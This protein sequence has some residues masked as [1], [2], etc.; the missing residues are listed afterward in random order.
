MAAV[1]GRRR[2]GPHHPPSFS[3]SCTST[4]DVTS[5]KTTPRTNCINLPS[6]FANQRAKR[7]KGKQ[8]NCSRVAYRRRR[9]PSMIPNHLFPPPSIPSSLSFVACP[10]PARNQKPNPPPPR[11]HTHTHTHDRVVVVCASPRADTTGDWKSASPASAH[12]PEVDWALSPPSRSL[13][14]PPNV[15]GWWGSRHRAVIVTSALSR[16]APKKRAL[17]GP[18]I[19]PHLSHA[20]TPSL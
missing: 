10:P 18:C 4:P 2:P 8:G 19:Y 15:P 6:F 20:S 7:K 14:G 16:L 13:L 1:V 5:D 3:S 11:H 12:S 17:W 9:R